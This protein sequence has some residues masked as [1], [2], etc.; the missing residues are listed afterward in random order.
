MIEIRCTG[1]LEN[2]KICGKLL[3][4]CEIPVR[5][6]IKCPRCGTVHEEEVDKEIYE[7]V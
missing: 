5:L 3:L 2:G 7:L 4:K 6:E 1:I